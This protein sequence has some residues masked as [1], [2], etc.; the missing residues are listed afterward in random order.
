M[1]F[2]YQTVVGFLTWLDWESWWIIVIIIEMS[3]VIICGV[4]FV[5]IAFGGHEFSLV[6]LARWGEYLSGVL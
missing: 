1:E 5:L 2:W 6:T 4:S 3:I